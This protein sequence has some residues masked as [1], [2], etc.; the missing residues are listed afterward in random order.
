M[1]RNNEYLSLYNGPRDKVAEIL[2]SLKNPH[3][4]LDALECLRDLQ[5]KEEEKEVAEKITDLSM[6]VLMG[7]YV[8]S[9]HLLRESSIKQY[10]DEA[11]KFND[12]LTAN[13]IRIV[14]IDIDIYNKYISARSVSKDNKKLSLNSKAKIINILRMFLDFLVSRKYVSI[15]TREIKSKRNKKPREY[16]CQSDLEKLLRCID[17]RPERFK[18]ENLIYKVIVYLLIDT[19]MRRGELISLNWEHIDFDNSL[20][21]LL[22]SMDY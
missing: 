22:Q 17:S 7:Q 15:D 8:D 6:E 21:R 20:L 11:E 18:H 9:L 3:H 5:R 10:R 19:G 2:K 16:V 1:D 12:Y 4:I 14:D 13:S